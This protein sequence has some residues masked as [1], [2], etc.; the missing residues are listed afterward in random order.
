METAGRSR[1][2]EIRPGALVHGTDGVAGRVAE[3]VVSPRERRVVALAVQLASGRAVQVPAEAVR[4]AT[5]EA[6]WVE[7]TVAELERLPDWQPEAHAPA[8]L[9]WPGWRGLREGGAWLALPGSL[10]RMEGLER[11][12]SGAA[13]ARP[14]ERLVTIRRG[15]RVLASD[16]PIGR[17]DQVL[18]DAETGRVKHLVVRQG[19]L[20]SRD[21]AVPADWVSTVEDGVVVLEASRDSVARLPVYRPDDE[22]ERDVEDALQR[23]ELLRVLA[24]P[25]RPEVTDG[26]VRLRGHVH[27]R[28][29]AARAEEVARS[30]P[31][32]ADV[33][34]ELVVD[35]ELLQQV[36]ASV[37]ADEITRHLAGYFLRVRDG[38]VELTGT[39][40]SLEAAQALERAIA[41]VAGVRG[42]ANH[43]TGLD[44]PP[45]WRR[46][47]QPEIDQAVYATDQEVGRVDSVVIDPDNR[48]VQAVV[49]AGEFPDPGAPPFAAGPLWERR[50][51]VPLEDVDRVTPGGVFLR[52]H[53]G[54]AAER[55]DLREDEYPAAP[56]QWTPPF[57]YE[58]RH[59]R[60]PRRTGD[61]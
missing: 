44:I 4:D 26:V 61:G 37:Q 45:G 19:R 22:L 54:E 16:G 20:F 18:V 59:V 13:E 40:P 52:I 2:L 25:V 10:R 15:Q 33:Q 30:V 48:R 60:W 12:I 36:V 24:L 35:H 11:Q 28:A 9:S 1:R 53:A 21:V 55:P 46:V 41:R 27:N 47:V 6:V 7:G 32:V 29:L 49:V 8:A 31:G 57:P 14:E 34:N 50:V 56:A 43:M 42:I 51:V 38:L 3:V 23:E 58:S 5:E 17:V 39:A